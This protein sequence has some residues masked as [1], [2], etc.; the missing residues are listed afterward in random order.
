METATSTSPR[1]PLLGL[2]VY[3]ASGLSTGP[4]LLM[5]AP[6]ADLVHSSMSLRRMRAAMEGGA[7]HHLR[8]HHQQVERVIGKK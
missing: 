8:R 3:L 7:G 4:R 2:E 5:P 1:P 6:A